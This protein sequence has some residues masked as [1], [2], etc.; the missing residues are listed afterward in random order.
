MKIDSEWLKLSNNTEA[1]A[2]S[3]DMPKVS[4]KQTAK[5]QFYLTVVKK[6][7]IFLLNAAFT[8]DDDEKALRRLLIDTMQTLKPT[9]NPLSLE[10]A[11]Q[12]ILKGN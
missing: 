5:R 12:Q 4:D 3:Y 6:D 10:K 7:H 9:D 1:L 11:R 2:W 8:G